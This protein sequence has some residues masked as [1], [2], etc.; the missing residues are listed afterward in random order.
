MIKS[1]LLATFLVLISG[2]M[3]A[4]PGA[5]MRGAGMAGGMQSGRFYGKIVD[6]KTGK[7]VDAA[8]VQLVTVKFDP[9][10]KQRKDTIV[11]GML[12]QGNGDFA[13]ENVPF[14]GDYRLKITAI[15]YKVIEQKVSFLSPEIQQKLQQAFMQAAA[16]PKTDSAQAG[17]KMQPGAGNVMEIIRKALGSDMSK[18]MSLADKDLGN[19]KLDQEAVALDNVTVTATRSMTLAV[20]RK[21]FSVDKTLS[22]SGGTA[23]DIMRQIP[24]VNV[25]IDGGVT[26]RNTSPTLFVDGRPTTLTLDQ[27]PADAIQSVELITN[28]SAKY[29]ASGGGAAIL[30]VVMKK[31]RKS[32]YNGSIRAGIDSRARPNLGGEFNMRQGKFNS[33]V[34]GQLGM[35]KSISNS[36]IATSYSPTT[37]SPRSDIIQDINNTSQGYFGF[38]RG[39]VDYFIDNRNTLTA[40]ANY[41]RGQ[42][43]NEETNSIRYDSFYT[44]IKRSTSDRNTDAD[45]YFQNVGATLS[46]KHNYAKPG[47]ELTAD[48]NLNK[49]K[50]NNDANFNSQFYNADNTPMG[51]AIKQ[52]THSG[53]SSTYWVIQTDYANPLTD[54]LKLETGLRA[55]VR[56]FTS[57]NNNSFYDYS[58]GK[59][60][61]SPSISSNYHFTDQVYAAYA[62]V[63]GKAGNLGYNL[64][65]R[66][67]SSSYKGGVTGSDS[68]FKVNYPISLFPSAFFS[69]KIGDKSDVQLN[70]TRRI[71]RPNFFQLIPYIDYTD[72][73]N[74]RVGNPALTPEFTNSLEANFSHQFTNSHNL[75]FSAY[76]KNTN[77]LITNNQYKGLNPA[78]SD[79]AIFNT[80]INANSSTRYGLELTSRNAFTKKFDVT[81]NLNFYNARIN[82]NNIKNGLENKQNSFFGK[83]TLTQKIGKANDWTIQLNGDY[84]SKTVVPVNSGGGGRGGFMGGGIQPAGSNGFVNPNYGADLSVRKDIIKNK[85]GQGYQGTITLSMNDIFRTRIYDVVT[86]SD[87][88]YQT[89]RRRRDPQILRLQFNWRF[90]KVDT[91]LFKRKNLKGEMEGMQEGMSGAQ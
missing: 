90:G 33:F 84:Q 22:A 91:N 29:D 62:T 47:H 27:I 30:N 16:A 46:F 8:S 5:G 40:S 88:F 55:Q 49:N 52:L 57:L 9:A 39:G 86:S 67:E 48:V 15:G 28:P 12:T 44:P 23:T 11:N 38:L 18:L 41:M 53:S 36:D 56:D 63:T 81:S 73:L 69:Y 59:F 75:L 31:N 4:Q 34:S 13:L 20:D 21:I 10:T 26:V 50:S 83:I 64:G 60:V 78:T 82:S 1:F 35:R 87:F 43:K 32:G 51:N 14:M 19:I 54:N 68:S 71:N 89:L 25:D 7:G 72:P 3:Y 76:Y 70:Y 61:V 66:A 2:F 58:S 24:S 85:N 6:A 80:F 74:L 79:S 77:D 37:L 42:F 65:L 45:G 17:A